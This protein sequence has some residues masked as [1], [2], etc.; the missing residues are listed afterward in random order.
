[1]RESSRYLHDAFWQWREAYPGEPYWVHF[2]TVDIHGDFPAVPPFS[3]LFVPP[4]EA[5]AWLDQRERRNRWH[6]EN[7]VRGGLF[8]AVW[9]EAGIDRVEFFTVAQGLYDEAMAYNDYQLGRLV[10]R[11]KAEGEWENTILIVAADHGIESAM[12]DMAVA[13]QDSLPPAWTYAMLRPS[14]SRI[15]LLF[16]WSGRIPGGQWFREPVVSMVDVLPTILDLVGLPLPEVL[17]GQSLAPLLLGTGEVQ[18]RPVILDESWVSSQT[19][20]YRAII[21]VIDGRWGASLEINP[22]PNRPP[23]RNRPSPLLLF[24]LWDDPYCLH[25]VHEERPDLVEEYTAF[26]EEQWEAH[27]M[28]RRMFTPAEAAVWTPEQLEVLRALGYIR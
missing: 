17:Q 26:L 15:P 24:D 23:E 21:E 1:L 11:L 13:I 22:N 19:G 2:Q 20:D 3:G 5:E 16:V 6:Q 4:E 9:E 8:S 7:R 27:H 28:L 10:E 18:S 25:S 12:T 14:V